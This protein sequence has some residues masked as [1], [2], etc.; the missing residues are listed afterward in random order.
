MSITSAEWPQGIGMIQ[1]FCCRS[2]GSAGFSVIPHL[3]PLAGA[4]AEKRQYEDDRQYQQDDQAAS[5]RFLHI[6][7]I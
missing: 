5:S 3:P 1:T 2:H 4:N 6:P 7:S